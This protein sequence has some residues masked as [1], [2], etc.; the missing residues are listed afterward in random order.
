MTFIR[1]KRFGDRVYKYKVE[2]Y[3]DEQGRPRQ[4]VLEYLGREA[5][6]ADGE[7]EARPKRSRGTMVEEILPFG[8][9]A[10]LHDTAMQIDLVETIDRLAPRQS[11]TSVGK[12]LL[13]LAINHHTG[14]VALEDVGEWYERSM[15]RYWLGDPPENF[16]EERLLGVLDT[17]CKQDEDLLR[18]KTWIISQA[19]RERVEVKWSPES[20]YLYYDR[21]QTLY[22]GEEC[23][24]GEFGYDTEGQ[25]KRR[26]VGMA[27]VIRRGDRFPVLYR[28]F[29]GD[30]PD[31]T[32]F[33]SVV[34]RLDGAGL[35]DL[36]LVVDRGM[37]SEE[38]IRFVADTPF[39]VV[40]GVRANERIVDELLQ[41]LRDEDVERPGN[42]LH[43]GE[44]I[45]CVVERTVDTSEGERKYVIYQDPRRR[46]EE[47]ASLLERISTAEERLGELEQE[48]ATSDER[49]R[50]RRPNW[51][52]RMK[53]IL[54]GVGR[55]FKAEITDG[56]LEWSLLEDVVEDML[57]RVG[58]SILVSTDVNIPAKEVVDV[59]LDKDEVEKVWRLG[60]GSLGLKGINHYKRDRVVSYLFVC[61]LAHLLW[62]IL[63]YRLRKKRVHTSVER[64]LR[65][66]HR[67]EFVRL[68]SGKK[69]F[70]QTPPPVGLEKKLCEAFDLERFKKVT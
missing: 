27:I 50:G 14:R 42:R 69:E 67:V 29:R 17:V 64:C 19:L 26:K 56:R 62:A 6:G 51:E 11:T 2:S 52:R 57:P 48:M 61:Y 25:R 12:A 59:Y 28:V 20:R 70:L 10:L 18:D 44:R 22:F 47:K 33:T 7:H 49:G 36:V 31:V 68:R 24:Y 37:K 54:N 39:S 45:F 35:K 32:T 3:R 1:E 40:T 34:D 15:L 21:T 66:L 9:L 41:G 58:R 30:R 65:A 46:G 53:D 8:D 23:F 43:R 63:R 55:Y 16:T 4:R 5:E 60:K 38:N 13:L